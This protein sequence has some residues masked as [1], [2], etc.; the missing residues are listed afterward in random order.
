[1]GW[2]PLPV[3]EAWLTRN[4]PLLTHVT[5]LNFGCSWSSHTDVCTEILWIMG[6]SRP[7]VHEV[8]Q[9]LVGST[10]PVRSQEQT[11]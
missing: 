8:K 4:T 1:M 2:D 5:L 9:H 10:G 3:H 7:A 6:P 11:A